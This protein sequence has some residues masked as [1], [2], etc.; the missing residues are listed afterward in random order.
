[1]QEGTAFCPQCNAPQIRVAMPE[2]L[3]PPPGSSG[4]GPQPRRHI[5]YSISPLGT[6]IDW[7]QALPA[8]ALAGLIAAILM[9]TPLMAFG[10]GMLIGGSLS[11]VFYRRRNPVANI[12]PGMGSRL[13]MVSGVL[14]GCI[15]TVLL[16]ARTILLH[17]WGQ[18]REK[19]LE[20]VAQ[21]A[22]RNPDPQAQQALEFFKTDQGIAL[23]VTSAWIGTLVAFVIFSGLGGAIG[24][25]LLRPEATAL[26]GTGLQTSDL[27]PRT[28]DLGL[29]T[30]TSDLGLQTSDLLPARLRLKVR[31]LKS[32]VRSPISITFVPYVGTIRRS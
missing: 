31:G 27:R 13:G 28:S 10:L 29:Q 14:G 8:T 1:M 20:V 2:S 12:T 22:A 30:S 6:R 32:D 3:T 11:V 24:A 19:A 18:V 25:A 23:L 15:F 7:S 5:R 26:A 4:R 16:S 21:A 17:E 9:L